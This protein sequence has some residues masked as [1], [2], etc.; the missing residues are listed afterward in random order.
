MRPFVTLFIIMLCAT[1]NI[2]AQTFLEHLRKQTPGMGKVT[3]NQSKALDELVNGKASHKNSQDDKTNKP[4][5]DITLPHKTDSTKK[6]T[7]AASHSD[8][9]K[10]LAHESEKT[11]FHE[12]ERKTEAT[13]EETETPAVDM[14]KKVMRSSYKVTG[15]R[16]QAYAGGNSRTDRQK[17][18][19]AGNAIKMKYPDQPVYVH[20]YSPRWICRVGNYRTLTE[21]SIMLKKIQAMGYKQACIVKGKI[22]VQD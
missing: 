15:Y 18:E 4:P 10:H 1:T 7:E 20:F 16:V 17:A 3:V 13:Q 2:Q 22:T 5:K 14:S 8:K 19:Q 6:T 11:T 21:A 12:T 9:E